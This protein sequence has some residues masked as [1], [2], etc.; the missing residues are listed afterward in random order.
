[1]YY[2]GFGVGGNGGFEGEKGSVLRNTSRKRMM[3]VELK[4][5]KRKEKEKEKT[6]FVSGFVDGMRNEGLG[7]G[8][9]QWPISANMQ[10]F[11]GSI[12]YW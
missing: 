12:Y 10:S 5:E 7:W 1:M 9:V 8:V 3:N 2:F 4:L 11:F 6:H